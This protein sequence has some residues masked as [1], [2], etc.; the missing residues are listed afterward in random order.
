VSGDPSTCTDDQ[1]LDILQG[2]MFSAG[3]LAQ[4]HKE[5]SVFAFDSVAS[6]RAEILKRM[7]K[8]ELN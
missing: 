5:E 3:V 8:V 2:G 4:D 7:R 6:I 1:L